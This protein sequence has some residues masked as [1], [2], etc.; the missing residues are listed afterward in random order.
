MAK[1]EPTKKTPAAK[2]KKAA[3]KP[4]STAK[5][6]TMTAK[7]PVAGKKEPSQEEI[8]AKAHQI[9]LDRIAKGIHRDTDED[10]HEAVK[11]LKKKK[12]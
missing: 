2:P 6:S 11:E 10:W 3:A 12:K 9:Y 7:K 5:P 1:K 8:R 4:K